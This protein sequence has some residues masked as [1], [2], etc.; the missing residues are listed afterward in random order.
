MT[1]LT[2]EQIIILQE[3]LWGW[4]ESESRFPT[5]IVREISSKLDSIFFENIKSSELDRRS[6]V[7]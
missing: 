5:E 1:K 2:Q 7:V 6:D 4:G 3:C